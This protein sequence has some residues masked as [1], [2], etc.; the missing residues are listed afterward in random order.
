MEASR[1]KFWMKPTESCRSSYFKLTGPL[2]FTTSYPPGTFS[3]KEPTLSLSKHSIRLRTLGESDSLLS[4]SLVV[5]ACSTSRVL[6]TVHLSPDQ[7][8]SEAEESADLDRP[9]DNDASESSTNEDESQAVTVS[10]TSV[11]LRTKSRDHA[12]GPA[13]R[14]QHLDINT[15]ELPLKVLKHKKKKKS[16]KRFESHR[17]EFKLEG[18]V[19]LHQHI[20]TVQLASAPEGIVYSVEPGIDGFIEVDP[21]SGSLSV[22]PKLL[23]D[24]YEEIRF[25]AYAQRD[26]EIVVS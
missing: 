19:E 18:Q 5:G 25:S 15:S 6:V 21:T 10:T 4:Q 16:T 1:T 12:A 7:H 13:Q 17:Y 14:E 24:T 8:A 3:Q 2:P 20:G 9:K 22:G 23:E 11:R 26:R